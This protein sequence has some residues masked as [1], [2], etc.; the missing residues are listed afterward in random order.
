VDLRREM[1]PIAFVDLTFIIANPRGRPSVQRNAVKTALDCLLNE[2]VSLRA[3]SRRDDTSDDI[4]YIL[5]AGELYE[6]G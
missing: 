3:A 2:R 1:R 6:G 4:A 5:Q